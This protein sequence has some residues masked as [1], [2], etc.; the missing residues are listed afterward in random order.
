MPRLFRASN[1]GFFGTFFN[2]FLLNKYS[3]FFL[4]VCPGTSRLSGG[5]LFFDLHSLRSCDIFSGLR[6]FD[7]FTLTSI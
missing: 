7:G 5:E 1:S 4:L 6:F 3:R 2:F